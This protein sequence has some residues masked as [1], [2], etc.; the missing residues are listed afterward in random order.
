MTGRRYMIMLTAVRPLMPGD[1]HRD[2]R[3][4]PEEKREV[5]GPAEYEAAQRIFAAFCALPQVKA[6]RQRAKIVPLA[7][8]DTHLAG[9]SAPLVTRAATELVGAGR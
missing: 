1:P 7:G 4:W 2:E 5:V 8:S 3:R 9:W 6:G